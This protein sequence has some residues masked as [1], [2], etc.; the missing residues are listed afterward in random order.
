MKETTHNSN[1]EGQKLNDFQILSPSTSQ[2]K[3]CVKAA[4]LHTSTAG[5]LFRRVLP[6]PGHG[7]HV[8]PLFSHSGPVNQVLASLATAQAL[9]I[10]IELP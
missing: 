5:T 10:H 8:H 3:I 6:F 1:G 7:S 9:S 4:T 2:P